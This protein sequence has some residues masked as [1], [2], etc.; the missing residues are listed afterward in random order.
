MVWKDEDMID[1]A[2]GSVRGDWRF[3]FGGAVRGA[4]A[5]HKKHLPRGF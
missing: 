2:R 1:T 4:N 3:Q 5:D